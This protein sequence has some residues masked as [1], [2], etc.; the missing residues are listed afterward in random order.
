MNIDD[1]ISATK[2]CTKALMKLSYRNY[3]NS[4][5]LVDC[6]IQKNRYD[7]RTEE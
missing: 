6:K 2:K 7:K 3:L 5:R 1:M 4:E